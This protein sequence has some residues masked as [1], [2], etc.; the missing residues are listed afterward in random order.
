MWRKSTRIGRPRSFG[1][2][3]R[4]VPPDQVSTDFVHDADERVVLFE[5]EIKL[6]FDGRTRRPGVGEEVL[7]PAAL[8]HTERNARMVSNCGCFAIKIRA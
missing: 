7:I 5:G 2:K 1:C 4:I 8:Y 6:S 3:S